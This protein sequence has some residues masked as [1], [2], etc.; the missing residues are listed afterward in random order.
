MMI[1][2]ENK[3]LANFLG[4]Y[5][6]VLVIPLVYKGEVVGI[7][8]LDQKKTDGAIFDIDDIEVLE[9]LAGSLAVALENARLYTRLNDA[10]MDI[11]RSLSIAVET[12]DPF[13]VGHSENV[14]KYSLAIAKRM[15]IKDMELIHIIQAAMLHDLGKIGV[16]DYILTKPGKLTAEEWIEMKVHTIKGAKILEPLPFMKEV[17]KIVKYHH[18]RWDGEGY[19]EGLK[20]EIIPL[21]A[22]ILSVA[23]SFDAMVSPR[24]YRKTPQ[25]R[26][27]VE[28]AIQELKDNRDAQ[29]NS[30]IVD[31][32]L[33]VLKENPNIVNIVRTF[34]DT[35]EN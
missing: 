13:M 25:M 5:D 17:S 21:G 24:V 7:V 35:G 4:A 31:I 16:H 34:P 33:D 2:S 26:F 32:F 6:T 22:R 18:E 11:T 14:T 1:E 23:D 27:S 20:G 15:N 28:Q 8:T 12:R 29:F 3:E 10:Y 19:P 9:S 30:E